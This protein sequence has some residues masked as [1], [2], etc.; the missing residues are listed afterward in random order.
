MKVKSSELEKSTVE[1]CHVLQRGVAAPF[2]FPTSEMFLCS[3]VAQHMSITAWIY[4]TVYK[5]NAQPEHHL[6][7]HANTSCCLDHFSAES[8]TEAHG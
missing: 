6:K 3:S 7:V 8:H 4:L 5:H 1:S 2:F